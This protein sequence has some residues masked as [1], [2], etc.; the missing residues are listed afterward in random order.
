MKRFLAI[1]IS[2]SLLAALMVSGL[3]VVFADEETDGEAPVAVGSS[4]ETEDDEPSYVRFTATGNDPFA[5]FPFSVW[6]DHD[7]IDPDD[8]VWAVI[9]YRTISELDSTGVPFKGQLY[10]HPAAEPF[11]PITY[12]F[13]GQWETAVIDC[14]ATAESATLDSKWDSTYYTDDAHIRFDPLESDR[15]AEAADADHDNA[16]VQDGDQIDVAWIAFFEKEEDARAYTG[17]EN[18]PFC[19][20]DADAFMEMY[21]INHMEAEQFGEVP[22][23][24]TPE[25][26]P[27][28]TPKPTT[29]PTDP[30]EETAAEEPTERPV[31]TEATEEPKNDEPAAETKKD[32]GCGGFAAGG[33]ALVALAAAVVIRKKH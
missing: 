20:L 19:L 33:I 16:V 23:R 13:S 31:E 14:L 2:L 29:P 17:V 1:L 7:Y 5:S 27:T 6:G 4:G 32:K 21:N 22:V 25:P 8:V 12:V 10:I 9:R 11:V 15:D 30:P 3:T 28:P 18:T 24:E 26:T